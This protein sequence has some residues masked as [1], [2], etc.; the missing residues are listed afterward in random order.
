M[1]VGDLVRHKSLNGYDMDIGIIM[2]SVQTLDG[3]DVVKMV[4]WPDGS[5]LPHYLYN[6]EVINEGR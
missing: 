6:L 4:L 5:I 1:K 2:E 3:K